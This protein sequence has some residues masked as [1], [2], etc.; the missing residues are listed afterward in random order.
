M[1]SVMLANAVLMSHFTGRAV[2]LPLDGDDYVE[3][4]EDLI[5]KST[6]VKP[7]VQSGSVDMDKSF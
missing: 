7:K 4:L 6:F 2:D 3:L 5:A 1:G